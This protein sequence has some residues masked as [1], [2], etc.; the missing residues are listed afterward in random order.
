MQI[1]PAIL[2]AAP[3]AEGPCISPRRQTCMLFQ[4]L[5]RSENRKDA[6]CR[7]A[8]SKPRR[9]LYVVSNLRISSPF[10]SM[11]TRTF[12]ML[13]D[14]GGTIIRARMNST[15]TDCHRCVEACCIPS[16]TIC[17][18]G[19]QCAFDQDLSIYK[20]KQKI[21]GRAQGPPLLPTT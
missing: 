7:T 14:K 11:Q 8:I 19:R 1:H 5:L 12:I 4:K 21:R 6:W 17:T 16:S 20:G 13:K 9:K 15:L 3:I 10:T 18:T 2:R